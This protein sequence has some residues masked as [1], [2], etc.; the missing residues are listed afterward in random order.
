MRKLPLLKDLIVYLLLGVGS[1]LLLIFQL[2]A[3]LPIIP[4]LAIAVLL[5]LIVR[6]RYWI[7]ERSGKKEDGPK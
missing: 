2:D 5:M 4:S 3:E 7:T 1:F 6:I